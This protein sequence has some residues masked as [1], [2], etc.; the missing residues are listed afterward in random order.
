MRGDPLAEEVFFRGL[1]FRSLHR[2]AGLVVAV[3]LAG[4]VFG[5]VHYDPD[6]VPAVVVAV[7]LGLLAL[8]GMALCVLVHRTG[9][10]AAGIVA[11]AA[12]NSVTVLSILAQR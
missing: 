4:L 5:L 8:F 11:H 6:P 10:L 2:V 7:Q 9:R 3:P 12:F 1:L